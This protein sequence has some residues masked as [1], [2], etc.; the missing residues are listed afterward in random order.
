MVDLRLLGDDDRE[1]NLAQPFAYL[2]KRRE[3]VIDLILLIG[4]QTFQLITNGRSQLLARH[5]G[6]LN[7]AHNDVS[8]GQA[9]GTRK[10]RQ[11]QI[12]QKIVVLG[13]PLLGRALPEIFY[14]HPAEQRNA[15]GT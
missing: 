11:P 8:T 13:T 12:L 2:S 9:D 15:A 4:M 3:G 7:L 5:V 14:R 1:G 10:M 6:E